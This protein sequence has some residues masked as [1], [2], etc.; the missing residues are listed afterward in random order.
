M[1]L[2][3]EYDKL[4]SKFNLSTQRNDEIQRENNRIFNSRLK[5]L[6]DEIQMLKDKNSE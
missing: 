3:Q 4:M 2:Q 6:E 1:N 5:M